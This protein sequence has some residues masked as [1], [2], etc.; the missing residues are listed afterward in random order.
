MFPCGPHR[1]Q[2]VEFG[3]S[4]EWKHLSTSCR[5]GAGRRSITQSHEF[6]GGLLYGQFQESER[7]AAII[8]RGGHQADRTPYGDSDPLTV[9]ATLYSQIISTDRP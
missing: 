4:A 3:F 1:R 6:W 8:L 2:Q 5:E 7:H 9:V